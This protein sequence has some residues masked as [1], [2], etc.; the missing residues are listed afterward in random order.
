MLRVLVRALVPVALAGSMPAQASAPLIHRELPGFPSGFS[1]FGV[2]VAGAGDVDRDGY[3]D[4]LVGGDAY[5]GIPGGAVLFSGFSGAVLRT[6][7]LGLNGDGFGHAVAGGSD[8]DADG[9]PDVLIG[10]PRATNWVP[11]SVLIRGYAFACSGATGALLRWF[12]LNGGDSQLGTTVGFTDDL[13]GD[14]VDDILL[15][16]LG[17]IWCPP[18]TPCGP[19]LPARFEIYSGATGILLRQHFNGA[20]SVMVPRVNLDGDGVDD[21]VLWD[22][23]GIALAFSG[24]TGALITQ[25][26]LPAA[27][28]ART[29][30]PRQ[31]RPNEDHFDALIRAAARHLGLPLITHDRRISAS[32]LVAVVR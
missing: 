31:R 21:Y 5:Y 19:I 22:W 2:A 32:G 10:A 7:S 3:A 11:P 13:D 6:W 30:Q 1:E 4:V 20:G 18:Q 26:P 17:G 16:A 25:V 29:D 12:A 8:I 14:G 28:A 15:G 9:V 27:T 24:V 23:S